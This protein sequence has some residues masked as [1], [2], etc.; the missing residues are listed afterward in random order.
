MEAVVTQTDADAPP[1]ATSLAVFNRTNRVKGYLMPGHKFVELDSGRWVTEDT[2][3]K[4]IPR[5]FVNLVLRDDPDITIQNRYAK[6][7]ASDTKNLTIGTVIDP[8][9]GWGRTNIS[10]IDQLVRL[11]DQ[12]VERDG[13]KK[14]WSADTLGQSYNT[15]LVLYPFSYWHYDLA[16]DTVTAHMRKPHHPTKW[17]LA[18]SIPSELEYFPCRQTILFSMWETG[19][20]PKE[21]GKYLKQIRHLIVPSASQIDVFRQG[22]DGDISVVPLG[23]DTDAFAFRPRPQRGSDEPFTILLYG[24]PLTSRKS[25]METVYEVCWRAFYSGMYGEVV[26]DW[27]LILKTRRGI[28]GAGNFPLKIN[29]PHVEILSGDYDDSQLADLCYKADVGIALSKFEGF[30]LC[31]V[32]MSSTGLPVILSDNSGQSD[33][34]DIN[35]NIPVPTKNMIS[36]QDAYSGNEN[37]M[38]S[39]PDW[40]YA[41]AVL[42]QEYENWKRRGKTQSGLGER[43]ALRVRSQYQWK[44]AA[45]KLD[46]IIKKVMNS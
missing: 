11:H 10:L 15:D 36:A 28:V 17:G 1:V 33:F 39:E 29:D 2:K 3:H 22:Y 43:A 18:L 30:G 23:V 40:D 7:Y 34:C 24:S 16:P 44:H 46:D 45:A 41:A 12:P 26:D 8:V 21:W 20:L 6:Y 4:P 31:P 25:P 14:A 5:D 37:W 32:E 38:W 13:A 27:K 42:R 9:T 19:A 35:Y